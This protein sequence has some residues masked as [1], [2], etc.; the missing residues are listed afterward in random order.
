MIKKYIAKYRQIP[1]GAKAALWFTACGVMQKCISFLT[2]PLFTRI[3]TEE[4]YGQV[5]V[6]NSWEN[7]LTVLIT[8]NLFYGSFNTAMIKFENER[9]AYVS[10]ASSLLLCMVGFFGL[11][12]FGARDYVCS[13]LN[14]P[15]LLVAVMLLQIYFQSMINIWMAR[16]KFEYHYKGVIAVTVGVFVLSP[17]ASV[18]AVLSTAYKA[19]ARIIVNALAFVVFGAGVIIA[20]YRKNR[21]F[22]HKQYWAYIIKFNLPLVPHY[23]STSILG[24]AD[25]IMIERMIS[26]ASAAVYSIAYSIA[27]TLSI[28]TSA[29]N[30]AFTPWLYRKLKDREYDEIPQMVYLMYGAVAV[31]LAGVMLF[32]PEAIMILAPAGYY[33]AVW[34]IPP[35]AA[36]ILFTFLYQLFANIEFYFEKSQFIMAASIGSALLNLILNFIF[37]PKF[38]FIA[39]AYT[40]LVCYVFFGITHY[41]FARY[42]MKMQGI[43]W[44]FR[45]DI[46]LAISG[47]FFI[48][49]TAVLLLYTK[50]AARYCVIIGLAVAAVVLRRQIMKIIN[51]L[52]IKK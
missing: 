45:L 47:I 1:L 27:M 19:E 50:T 12:A 16:E 14:M 25:R 42:I 33:D 7:L 34:A 24:Q 36:S 5:M 40:T 51:R 15:G 39:A 32:G 6:Y 31:I 43:V 48:G 8:L 20:I 44:M 37:I 22:F 9:N 38:G 18:A 30:Q 2:T 23:L 3:L 52:R 10:A 46:I 4:Q 29:V 26:S 41:L 28:V 35:V 13:L 21:T 49:M 17:A 11:I